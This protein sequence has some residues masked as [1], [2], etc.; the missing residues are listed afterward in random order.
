MK[1]AW[2][3]VVGVLALV[4]WNAGANAEGAKVTQKSQ[5][6]YRKNSPLWRGTPQAGGGRGVCLG[7]A[8]LWLAA[9]V[10]ALALPE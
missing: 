10:H 5:K 8:V 9:F 3:L 1:P 2:E 4:G 7:A 6:E